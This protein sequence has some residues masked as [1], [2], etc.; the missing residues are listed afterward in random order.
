M[1]GERRG[2]GAS[3]RARIFLVSANRSLRAASLST[4]RASESRAF[5]PLGARLGGEMGESSRSAAPPQLGQV[6]VVVAAATNS[7]NRSP[8]PAH[9]N[10]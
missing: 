8:Q 6:A 9:L 7:S 1:L 4:R 5:G 10:S 2:G 3:P